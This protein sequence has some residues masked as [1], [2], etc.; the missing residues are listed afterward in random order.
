MINQEN[1]NKDRSIVCD[2][3]GYTWIPTGRTILVEEPVEKQTNSG[4]I[5]PSATGTERKELMV[6]AIGD[7]V[8]NVKVGDMVILSLARYYQYTKAA[9]N[10]PDVGQERQLVLPL[11][12]IGGKQYLE[13]NS[14]DVSFIL[15]K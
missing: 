12:T 9:P 10:T 11:R 2:E 14:D 6:L 4:I 15:K 3:Q 13:V 7:F 5:L 8:Q 1:K